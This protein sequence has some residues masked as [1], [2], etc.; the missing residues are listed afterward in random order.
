MILAQIILARDDFVSDRDD[1]EP[2]G[3]PVDGRR[4]HDPPGKPSERKTLRFPWFL[5]QAEL[6]SSLS[7]I[8][9]KVP[10]ICQIVCF[11]F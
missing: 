1:L 6:L 10:T 8:S 2:G 5:R 7:E 3:L 11:S 9:D 4:P